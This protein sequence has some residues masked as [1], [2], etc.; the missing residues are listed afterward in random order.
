ME[1]LDIILRRTQPLKR[2]SAH[3]GHD[4]HT[5]GDVGAI[6]DFDANLTIGRCDG[7]HDI[8]HDVQR[9]VFHRPLKEPTNFFLGFR[10]G[11]PVII[12]TGIF[13]F[14]RAHKGQ[15]LGACHIFRVA[16]V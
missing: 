3:A 6:R 7:P 14:P 4:A 1:T 11:H 2:N 16:P 15:V 5:G 10:R 9:A 12:R 13:F 8:R